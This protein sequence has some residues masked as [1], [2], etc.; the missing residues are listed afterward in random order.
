MNNHVRHIHQSLVKVKFQNG[1][2]T[3]V[4]RGEG[5]TFEC[6]CGKRF[7]VPDSHAKGCNDEQAESRNA[8]EED[9]QMCEANSDASETLDL[10]EDVDDTPADCFGAPISCEFS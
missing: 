2:V 9:V 3:E 6:K 8:I 4:K 7:K 5:G 1:R 10:N